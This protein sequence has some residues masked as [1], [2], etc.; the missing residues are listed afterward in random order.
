MRRR[1][2]IVKVIGVVTV[3]LLSTLI[4]GGTSISQTESSQSESTDLVS[5]FILDLIPNDRLR[6][7]KLV[8]SLNYPIRDHHSFTGQLEQMDK[9]TMGASNDKSLPINM[10]KS[11][12]GPLDFPIL[13]SRSGLEKLHESLPAIELPK[14]TPP[15]PPAEQTP[16]SVRAVFDRE[17]GEEPECARRALEA[18]VNAIRGGLSHEQA[19]VAGVFEG[20]RCL[21]DRRRNG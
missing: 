21:E 16:P 5:K 14:L 17:F 7:Y 2:G 15:T 11:S 4:I 1:R 3:L 9:E 13:T 12:L 18:Y 20:L 10:V 19:L 8:A 6:A